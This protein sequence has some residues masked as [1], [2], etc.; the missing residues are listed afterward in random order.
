MEKKKLTTSKKQLSVLY[1]ARNKTAK[2]MVV[3][4]A[5]IDWT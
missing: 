3:I 5:A 4:N 1:E 2:R